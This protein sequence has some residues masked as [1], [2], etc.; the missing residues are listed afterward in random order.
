MKKPQILKNKKRLV[1]LGIGGVSMSALAKFCLKAGYDVV[2]YDATPSQV[3]CELKSLGVFV[4]C[5]K[6][7]IE[8]GESDAVVYTSAVIG[9]ELLKKA[10]EQNA[11]IIKR[12]ELLGSVLSLFS[13]SVAVAGSHGKTT[14]TAMLAHILTC[15][16]A[17]PTC[18]IGGDDRVFGNF[19][20]GEEKI[21]VAEACE[22][23]KNFLDLRPDVAVVTNIDNDHLDSFGSL[24]NE[25]NSFRDFVKGS[26]RVFNAD[27]ENS[28]ALNEGC[29][30]SFGIKKPAFVSARDLY[31]SNG[32]YSF[33]VKKG[34]LILGRINLAVCGMHNVYN[35]LAAIAVADVL[36][37]RFS[38]IK[39]ALE[40]F[41]GV[42][43]REEFLGTIKNLNGAEVYADY[44]H[45]PSEL[46]AAFGSL[47]VET[48]D[49]VVFQPHTYS[50]TRLLLPD[51]LTVLKSVPN[52]VIYKT[53]PARESFDAEGSAH[54]LYMELSAT[55]KKVRYAESP[56][57][58]FSFLEKDIKSERFL[59][60]GAGDIYDMAKTFVKKND[61]GKTK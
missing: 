2:G 41:Y 45:H 54:K 24:E 58:L 28:A 16:G 23:K 22:Y 11:A 53:Y 52:L 51:F 61:C 42:K 49:T 17:H 35:A 30:V 37:V 36:N 50:R 43:R 40:N 38:V 5:D 55:G 47:N 46:K 3:T 33:T 56:E 8:I 32:K 10:C 19:M 13:K 57:E 21:A 39:K 6:D 9:D 1:F 31:R 15:E 18:F 26:L 29:A 27:D 59:F 60:F 7:R 25:I 44:A 34:S 14:T 48:T 12:S 20:Y 4:T